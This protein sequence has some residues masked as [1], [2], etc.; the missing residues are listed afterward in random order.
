MATMSK[1]TETPDQESLGLLKKERSMLEDEQKNENKQLITKIRGCIA[2]ALLAF[3]TAV[4]TICVQA[5]QVSLN[6]YSLDYIRINS[7]NT[8]CKCTHNM[9]Y[10]RIGHPNY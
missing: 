3:I 2:A 6:F 4:S 8:L 7:K 10:I 1:T 5:L 9:N